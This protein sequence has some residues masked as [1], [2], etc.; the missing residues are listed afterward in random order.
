VLID[1]F[2]AAIPTTFVFGSS[3]G[4]SY[5]GL[6]FPTSTL[7]TGLEK[8]LYNHFS[9][10]SRGEDVTLWSVVST[11]GIFIELVAFAAQSLL[12]LLIITFFENSKHNV[13]KSDKTKHAVEDSNSEE[14]DIDVTKERERLQNLN[15]VEDIVKVKDLKKW[16]KK[17]YVVKGI[18]FGVKKNECFGLLGNLE[19]F[20]MNFR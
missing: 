7:I 20:S 8:L 14:E 6:L 2:T 12:F 5:I 11:D 16:Y 9:F 17:D 1:M 13:T 18:T 19:E 4:W 15:Q 3:G 10:T